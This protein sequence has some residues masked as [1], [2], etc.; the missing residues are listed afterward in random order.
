MNK[1]ILVILDGFGEAPA[2]PGNAITTANTPNLDKM[3]KEYPFGILQASGE[4]VGLTEGSMGGSEVG[5]FTMGSGRITPQFL[6][7]INRD[8]KSGKFFENE[9][10]KGAFDY[11]KVKGKPLHLMGM[12]SDKGVH[13]HINHLFALLEWAKKEG[14]KDVYIHCI[15]DGRDVEERSIKTYLKQLQDKIDELGVGRIATIIGRYYSMDRDKNWDRTEVGYK[16]LTVGGGEKFDNPMTAVD[17]FYSE[18]DKLT[19]YYM[20]AILIDEKGLIKGGD[21]VIFFNYRT[22]RTKQLTAAF[23]HPTFVGFKKLIGKVWFVCMGPYSDHAPI[24]YTVPEIKN[25][26]AHWLSD[27]GIKQL[28]VAETEKYAHVT[29]FF[30]SQVEKPVEG[31]DRILIDSPK[32]PSYAQKPEMSAPQITHTILNSLESGE[33]EV[34]IVNFANCDLVGHSGDLKA[35]IQAVEVIDDCIGQIQKKAMEMGY[36]FM[37][38]GDHGNADDML[39]PDGSQKPAHS[40]NPVILLIAGPAK[41]IRKVRDGGLADVAPTLLKILDLPKP[42][43]MTGESLTTAIAGSR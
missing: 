2:G 14:L 18:D 39:Y 28:R 40:M 11:A 27:H 38:T 15:G 6:L 24:A 1:V 7:A 25:N 10:L 35:T 22:D 21:A 34:I 32:V 20:P 42:E 5:H 19:D 16:L 31:E 13:S 37:L 8:I 33:H 9:E 12:I 4:A 3:R 41:K 26:L 17:H 30:N 43:E 29:F 23:V 36:T